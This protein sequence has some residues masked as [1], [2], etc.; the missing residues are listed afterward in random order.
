ML[1]GKIIVLSGIN[2]FQGGPLSVYMDFIESLIRLGITAE[3]TV[4]AF[5]Y[6]KSLFYKYEKEINFIEIPISRKNYAYRLYYEWM[7]FYK[8]SIINKI[9]YWISLHDITPNVKAKKLFTYCHNSSPFYIPGRIDLKYD[10][11]MCLF[12]MF[13]NFLYKI[14]IKKNSYVIVQQEWLRREFK[15]RFKINNIIVAHPQ[16]DSKILYNTSIRKESNPH[17]KIKFIYASYPRTFKNFEIICRACEILPKEKNYQVLLTINGTENS[18]SKFLKQTYGS[19][20]K[21][22]WLGIQKRDKILQ[23]YQET[24]CMI[25]PSK[26]ETWGLPISE[27]KQTGKPIIMADLPYAH[28]TVGDYKKTAFF[29]VKSAEDLANKM[30][31]V[32]D[33]KEGIKQHSEEYIH[34]PY[35]QSWDDLCELLFNL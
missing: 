24:D 32:I 16:D 13:Y 12:S 9:D 25:F 7:Y 27:Y 8:Y 23:L 5:V 35:A 22:K 28:E 2:L 3:N 4:T 11:K 6:K 34:Q 14:N 29:D 30:L 18:Y 33:N 10:K 26:L 21:I 19:N 31:N 15:K 20:E 1:K 17:D